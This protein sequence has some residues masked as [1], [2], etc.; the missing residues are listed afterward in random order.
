MKLV[1]KEEKQSAWLSEGSECFGLISA[2]CHPAGPYVCY[3][4]DVTDGDLP[5]ALTPKGLQ[6]PTGKGV[7]KFIPFASLR[8][9]AQLAAE[10]V[11]HDKCPHYNPE[12]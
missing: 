8:I 9:V 11:D 3:Y 10:L 12:G 1:V 7:A 4:D 5:F 6:I 2:D